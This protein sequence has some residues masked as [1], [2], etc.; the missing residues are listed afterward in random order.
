MARETM[1]IIL[2]ALVAL[3]P[4]SG[5]PLSWLSY[6]LVVMGLLLILIGSTLRA[7]RLVMS[8]VRLPAVPFVP[9]PPT[10]V[11]PVLEALEHEEVVSAQQ[12]SAPGN[13]VLPRQEHEHER[14]IETLTKTIGRSR[15]LIPPSRSSRIAKF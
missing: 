14:K 5:L 15:N 2:G 6:G 1:V 12:V 8:V 10:S 7:R 13:K 3:S 4:W 9:T 11:P